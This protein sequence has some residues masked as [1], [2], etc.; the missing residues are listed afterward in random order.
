MQ[1]G[2]TTRMLA[3]AITV[4][5][6]GA[7]VLVIGADHA[8]SRRLLHAAAELAKGAAVVESVTISKLYVVRGGEISFEPPG[9]LDWGSRTLPGNTSAVVFIDHFALEQKAER[10]RAEV[11]HIKQLISSLSTESHRFDS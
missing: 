2:R 1:T 9:R 7:F 11:R 4:A 8:E 10:L 5:K 6:E 3:K